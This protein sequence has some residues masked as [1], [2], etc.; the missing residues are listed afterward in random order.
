MY[1]DFSK[2]FKKEMANIQKDLNQTTLNSSNLEKVI[3]YALEVSS[4]T[5]VLWNKSNVNTK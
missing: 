4:N 3:K 1:N 5:G 2:K